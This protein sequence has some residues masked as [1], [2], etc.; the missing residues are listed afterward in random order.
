MPYVI[1]SNN[2]YFESKSNDEKYGI[3]IDSKFDDD[4]SNGKY[5]KYI[6]L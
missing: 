1:F 6:N 2:E 3:Y 5:I 4:E